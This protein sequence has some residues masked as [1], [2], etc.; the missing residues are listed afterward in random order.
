MCIYIYIYIL[1]DIRMYSYTMSNTLCPASESYS[2]TLL[3]RHRFNV[4]PLSAWVEALFDQKN[5]RHLP[6]P[7]DQRETW[8]MF[9]PRTENMLLLVWRQAL[10]IVE[11]T[12]PDGREPDFDDW[13]K[14]STLLIS[15]NGLMAKL[16]S[17]YVLM[18]FCPARKKNY[19]AGN[20]TRSLRKA[21]RRP[22]P[23][24]MT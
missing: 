13:L 16:R 5:S 7:K 15:H 8:K 20:V 4:A 19:T 22:P 11:L 24:E 1:I 18:R 23:Q 21:I 2:L 3:V 10:M 9:A 17:S 12:S 6:F 14:R